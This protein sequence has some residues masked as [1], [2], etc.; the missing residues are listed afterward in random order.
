M[1]S[2]GTQRRESGPTRK[3]KRNAAHKLPSGKLRKEPSEDPPLA[4]RE[5]VNRYQT[6][7]TAFSREA[8]T[9]EPN[10]CAL[11]SP[12]PPG[13]SGTKGSIVT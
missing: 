4:A 10:A 6:I 12:P 5:L 2:G 9:S 7:A 13:P 1:C 8:W 11:I 3:N